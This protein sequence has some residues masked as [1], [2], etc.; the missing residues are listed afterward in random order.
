MLTLI[1][2]TIAELVKWPSV[3]C[4]AATRLAALREAAKAPE[5]QDRD[6]K[7][8][9]SMR[10]FLEG[11]LRSAAGRGHPKCGGFVLDVGV[12]P[13]TVDGEVDDAVFDALERLR[14]TDYVAEG[15]DGDGGAGLRLDLQFETARQVAPMKQG[16]LEYELVAKG[17]PLRVTQRQTLDELDHYD[18]YE[19]GYDIDEP[20]FGRDGDLIGFREHRPRTQR[21]RRRDMGT[22]EVNFASAPLWLLRVARGVYSAAEDEAAHAAAA[23]AELASDELKAQLADP[24]RAERKFSMQTQL[25]E[26]EKKIER[27]AACLAR[28]KLNE[29]KAQVKALSSSLQFMRKQEHVASCSREDRNTIREEL[30]LEN[31]RLRDELADELDRSPMFS[32]P[33]RKFFDLQEIAGRHYDLLRSIEAL[34][35]IDDGHQL[36]VD[37]SQGKHV[38]RVAYLRRRAIY[39]VSR[40]IIV[41][42]ALFT[43]GTDEAASAYDALVASKSNAESNTPA[44]NSDEQGARRRGGRG[45]G[46]G[47]GCGGERCGGRG[48]ERGDVQ[49]LLDQMAVAVRSSHGAGTAACAATSDTAGGQTP[50]VQKRCSVCL[51]SRP[52]E[53]YS[54]TQW[55]RGEG[56]LCTDCVVAKQAQKVSAKSDQ[57]TER[58]SVHLQERQAERGIADMHLAAAKNEG[59][60]VE[61]PDTGVVVYRHEGTVYVTA[62]GIGITAYRMNPPQCTCGHD[63]G[64]FAAGD[65]DASGYNRRVSTRVSAAIGRIRIGCVKADQDADRRGRAPSALT[66]AASRYLEN[67]QWDSPQNRELLGMRDLGMFQLLLLCAAGS[68]LVPARCGTCHG[69][70]KL[71]LSVHHA[72]GR[73][74]EEAAVQWIRTLLDIAQMRPG[75]S[76]L[77]GVLNHRD[78]ELARGSTPLGAAA[79]AGHFRCCVELLRAGANVQEAMMDLE[80]VPWGVSS[81]G[82]SFYGVGT[83]LHHMSSQPEADGL[84]QVLG[85]A[86]YPQ[87]LSLLAYGYTP[88]EPGERERALALMRSPAWTA[89]R[90]MVQKGAPAEAL[91]S[92]VEGLVYDGRNWRELLRARSVKRGSVSMLM[93]GGI[94]YVSSLGIRPRAA[95][96]QVTYPFAARQLSLQQLEE[97]SLDVA[98]GPSGIHHSPFESPFVVLQDEKVE[99][100]WMDDDLAGTTRKNSGQL[101]PGL[102]CLATDRALEAMNIRS[103]EDSVVRP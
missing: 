57:P 77:V 83:Y 43:E 103:S 47:G 51:R 44:A 22:S 78:A 88:A 18:H 80:D 98:I 48:G 65:D 49:T 66:E 70:Q 25:T 8:R 95:I 63:S 1:D 27:T 91:Q 24:G 59:E 76:G 7:S 96:R 39:D 64:N 2:K 102:G 17:A 62:E 21:Q 4:A 81:E 101:N 100:F 99:Q 3:S 82:V 61:Y 92:H 75:Y 90:G 86:H 46:R 73:L 45:K 74:D 5:F 97:L 12:L 9:A 26:L 35:Q 60:R 87:V 68:L 32:A 34:D 93:M 54:K 13:A 16:K 10:L 72:M 85:V 15:E 31:E 40:V 29:M 79:R 28:A 58:A 38:G 6:P 52:K 37:M 69:V 23:R 71:K 50:V 53:Q 67:V 11:A 14:A 55:G 30:E 56:R 41:Q 19:S 84:T 33:S 20:I 36:E 89:F 42:G 94:S